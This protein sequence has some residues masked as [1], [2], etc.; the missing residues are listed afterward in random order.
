MPQRGAT[1][2][3]ESVSKRYEGGAVALD[4][5]SFEVPAGAIC[6][7]VGPS[8]GGKT[9]ALKCVNRL[10]DPT[11][12]RIRVDGRDVM[13]VEPVSLRRGI[14]YVIQQVGLF[15]HWTVGQNVATVPALVGW[16]P[17]RIRERVRELLEL[18][19][20]DPARYTDRYPAQLSGGERQ[21]VG[22]A[23]ALAAEPPVMLMDE[24]FGAVDPIVR[25]RLQDE[26]LRIHDRIGMTV[27]FVTHD[28]DEAIKMGQR[29]A[30]IQGGH[31]VQYASPADLLDKPANDFV[32]RFVGADRGLK[33]LALIAVGDMPLRKVRTV[34]EGDRVEGSAGQADGDPYV[35]LLDTDGRPDGWVNV[36][37]AGGAT[38]RKDMADPSSPLFAR[39]TRARDALS[40]L[41]VRGVRTGVVVD[42][43]D[44][45]T[46]VLALDDLISLLGRQ[47]A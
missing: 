29:V 34:R 30:V 22:V 18:V 3:F 12:G 45:Y 13:S 23:R 40:Q 47:R 41:L 42:D 33:R 25:E 10:V 37:R 38:F 21:R 2:V 19:G 44:R 9:T 46:G 8:G 26:F 27:L 4:D 11:S 32:A 7:L 16:P 28:I 1:V 24:P 35:L 39:A 31:L 5:L 43:A 20:L 6:A 14:G 17:A 36:E 15:P